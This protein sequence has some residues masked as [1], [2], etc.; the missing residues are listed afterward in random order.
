[1][2]VLAN[3][4]V[5]TDA[6]FVEDRVVL[7][8]GDRIVAVTAGDDPRSTRARRHDLEGAMLLPGFVDSQVN[9]GGGALFNDDPSVATIR[10]IG[11]A[12]RRFGTTAFLS[13]SCARARTIRRRSATST[14]ATWRSC[15]R[16]RWERRW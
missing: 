5:L 12:H 3:G 11:E 6:G 14:L 10:T 4:R 8:D 9:G 2:E 15:P 1:M 7:I 13:T 16:S